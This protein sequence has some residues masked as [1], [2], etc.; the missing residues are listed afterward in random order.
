MFLLPLIRVH[1]GPQG[2]TRDNKVD[3]SSSGAKSSIAGHLTIA[4][5]ARDLDVKPWEVVRLI[6]TGELAAVRLVPQDA[7]ERYKAGRS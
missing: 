2:S 3:Q 7:L 6:E 1:K 4:E 5:A